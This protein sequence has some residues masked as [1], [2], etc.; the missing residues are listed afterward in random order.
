MK[1]KFVRSQPNI[2]G[3]THQVPN[4]LIVCREMGL[5][6]SRANGLTKVSFDAERALRSLNEPDIE[7][8]NSNSCLVGSHA[9]FYCA[10]S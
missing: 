8:S 9:L 5:A 3:A 2:L 1:E 10:T 7:N 6:K 4:S